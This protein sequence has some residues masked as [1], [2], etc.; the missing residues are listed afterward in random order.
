[1]KKV[2]NALKVPLG[3]AF[4]VGLAGGLVLASFA[5]APQAR[6]KEGQTY[7]LCQT[8]EA[9]RGQ[10]GTTELPCADALSTQYG[11]RVKFKEG[12]F[13]D[14]RHCDMALH[15]DLCFTWSRGKKTYNDGQFNQYT[16]ETVW[17]NISR[18]VDGKSDR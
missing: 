1:M 7:E 18:K 12:G 14:V 11:I 3:V 13:Q 17:Y 8:V 16:R 15:N 9:N 5:H 10:I 4:L 2:L 6:L